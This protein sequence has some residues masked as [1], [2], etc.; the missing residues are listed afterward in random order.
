MFMYS[1]YMGYSLPVKCT[2]FIPNI[3]AF[4]MLFALVS[5]YGRFPPNQVR[6]L[7]SKS[8]E[9]SVKA[10]FLALLSLAL[11]LIYMTIYSNL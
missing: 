7:L 2:A 1:R 6:I 9:F 11:N 3:L 4:I 8:L 10:N 5:V